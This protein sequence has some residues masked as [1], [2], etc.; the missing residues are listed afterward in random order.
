MGYIVAS[1][2]SNKNKEIQRYISDVASKSL[3]TSIR[4]GWSSVAPPIGSRSL[5]KEVG[6]EGVNP[7]REKLQYIYSKYPERTL[8]CVILSLTINAS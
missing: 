7:D 8:M 2:E 1:I 4:F 6:E 5:T 3:K